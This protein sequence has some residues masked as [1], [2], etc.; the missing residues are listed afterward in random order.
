MKQRYKTR[1]ELNSKVIRVSL[2][3]YALLNDISQ[4]EGVT[5]AEALPMVLHKLE[6]KPE[7]PRSPLQ[8]PLLPVD[9]EETAR[10][11][12][13]I[14][15]LEE[16]NDR[17]ALLEERNTFLESPGHQNEIIQKF[18]RNIDRN[19]YWT[20]G[21]KLGFLESAEATAE[22]LEGVEGA[23]QLGAPLGDKQFLRVTKEK[24]E[25]MTGWAFSENQ[26]LYIKFEKREE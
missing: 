1:A 3:D 22:D 12:D 25:D 8:I 5:I 24:P 15:Q 20:I 19:N 16:L 2:G 10:V 4:R 11:K 9:L 23:E 17:S 14:A 7:S 18:L 21:I 13:S 26:R 6:T